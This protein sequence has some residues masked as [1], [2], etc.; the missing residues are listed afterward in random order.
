M[1]IVCDEVTILL[2]GKKIVAS[3]TLKAK[4]KQ[5]VG[6]IGPNGSGKS[7]LLKA[8]YRLLKPASGTIFIDNQKLESLSIKES[9]QKMAVV[10]QHN[11]YNFDFT[12]QEVVLMGRSPHK[13]QMERDNEHDYAIVNDALIKVEMENYKDRIFSTL[14]GGEQQRI[15]LAR[16]FAQQTEFLILDEPTNHLD[17][18]HQLQILNIIRKLDITAIVALHDLN[19]AAMYCDFLYVLQEGEI[20][21]AGVPQEVLTTKLLKDIYEVD[22]NIFTDSETGILSVIYKPSL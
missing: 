6:I 22:A 2:A 7:T 9:A 5:F 8:V 19:I 14:S 3:V 21:A 17:I 15:V 16:A 1:K 13:K 20:K 11:H 10:S 12:V 18:K 4:N